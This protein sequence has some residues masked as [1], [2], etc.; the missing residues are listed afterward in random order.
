MR[1]LRPH[2]HL[3]LLVLLALTTGCLYRMPVQQGNLLDRA[4]VSQ[5]KT[6]MTRTQVMYLLGTPMVPDAFNNDRWDYYDFL[7]EGRG[8]VRQ[9]RRITVWFKNDEVERIEDNAPPSVPAPGAAQ[10]AG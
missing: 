9:S 4:Q 3:P 10:P 5:L 2:L 7:D 6:G 8:R 1:I